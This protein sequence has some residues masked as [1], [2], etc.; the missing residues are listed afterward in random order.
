MELEDL[1]YKFL[2][3]KY[4]KSGLSG[5]ELEERLKLLDPYISVNLLKITLSPLYF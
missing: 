2:L 4:K 1:D 5:I 3:T